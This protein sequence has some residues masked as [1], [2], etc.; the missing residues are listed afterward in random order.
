MDTIIIKSTYETPAIEFYP[1]EGKLLIEGRSLPENSTS[2]YSPLLEALE[3]YN[4][5]PASFTTVDIKLE[6]FNTSSSKCILNILRILQKIHSE[7]ESV[8]INWHHDK[9]DEEII[10]IGQDYSLIINVPF[11]IKVI[12]EN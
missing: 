8:T 12:P 1:K 3:N 7:N 5:N 11:N 6:Y 4:N 9:D 10:E 2:F